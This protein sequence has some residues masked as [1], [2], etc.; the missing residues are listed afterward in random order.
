M[1]DTESQ[2]STVWDRINLTIFDSHDEEGQDQDQKYIHD[3][4]DGKKDKENDA[5]I[6]AAISQTIKILS[7][8]IENVINK[9]LD[10]FHHADTFN[11]EMHILKEVSDIKAREM[12]RLQESETQNRQA[13]SVSL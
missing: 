4:N 13:I 11:N 10:G 2:I 12:K 3:E 7:Q 5:A 8:E 1:N 6:E 9:G